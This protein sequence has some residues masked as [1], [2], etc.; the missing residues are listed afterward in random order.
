M[1]RRI[2]SPQETHPPIVTRATWDAAQ[3]MGEAHG[4][5]RDAPALLRDQLPASAAED[6][7][8]R[9]NEAARLRKRLRK[10]DTTEDAHVR[11]VQALA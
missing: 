5:S 9:E 4:T 7:A 3:M 2:W 6:A 11:E 10:I 1:Q 8:R